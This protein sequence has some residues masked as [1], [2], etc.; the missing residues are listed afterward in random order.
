MSFRPTSCSLH[1]LYPSSSHQSIES[2]GRKENGKTH[3]AP[4]CVLRLAS[5]RTNTWTHERVAPTQRH[6][7]YKLLDIKDAEIFSHST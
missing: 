1:Q 5:N 7:D 3:P 2:N 6:R 4:P